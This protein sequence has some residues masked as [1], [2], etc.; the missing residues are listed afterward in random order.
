MAKA[1]GTI[2]SL[3]EDLVSTVVPTGRWSGLLDRP[4]YVPQAMNGRAGLAAVMIISH[5]RIIK[6]TPI[7]LCNS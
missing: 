2:K 3:Y 4:I 1:V 6:L 7:V 5:L